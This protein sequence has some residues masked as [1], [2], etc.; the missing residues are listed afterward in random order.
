[1]KST[2]MGLLL[3]KVDDHVFPNPCTSQQ[4]LY[5]HYLPQS[6]FRNQFTEKNLIGQ[7]LFPSLLPF[8]P[9]CLLILK[10]AKQSLLIICRKTFKISLYG[11]TIFN[12]LSVYIYQFWSRTLYM[13]FQASFF[14][15]TFQSIQFSYS[16]VR[17]L[18]NRHRSIINTQKSNTI[19]ASV[20]IYCSF[21]I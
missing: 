21:I 18:S 3:Q 4:Y 5:I 9:I 11:S 7:S 10:F 17:T 16:S 6:L 20:D 1:M 14:R 13:E 19:F 8:P 15:T 2:F 12:I